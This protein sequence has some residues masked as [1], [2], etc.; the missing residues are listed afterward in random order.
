MTEADLDALCLRAGDDALQAVG[1]LTGDL[2]HSLTH[3]VLMAAASSLMG[4]AAIGVV[5]AEENRQPAPDDHHVVAL[6]HAWADALK[7]YPDGPAIARRM[8]ELREQYEGG[9]T[10]PLW[11]EA[12][13]QTRRLIEQIASMRD[14]LANEGVNFDNVEEDSV[15]TL[16]KIIRGAKAIAGDLEETGIDDDDE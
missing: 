13:P 7:L 15:E 9:A 11:Y 4:Q 12:T 2:G 8:T 14:P 3:I 10:I 1:R 6:F 16:S 5:R